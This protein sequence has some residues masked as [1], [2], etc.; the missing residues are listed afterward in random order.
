MLL[1]LMIVCPVFLIIFSLISYRL[2]YAM[3]Y[4][5]NIEFVDSI[6]QVRRQKKRLRKVKRKSARLLKKDKITELEANDKINVVNEQLK[7]AK[8]EYDKFYSI[9]NLRKKQSPHESRR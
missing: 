7:Q 9:W 2:Y 3:K 5:K 8:L 4:P 1:F 6:K